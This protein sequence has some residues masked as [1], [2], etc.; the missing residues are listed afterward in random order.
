MARISKRA[1]RRRILPGAA[2]LIVVVAIL[3]S[4]ETSVSGPDQAFGF[5]V[6]WP[7]PN[8]YV[9]SNP[10][11]VYLGI[12]YT[13]S[14]TRNYTYVITVGS[15]VLTRGEVPIG[16]SSPFRVLV[17]APVPSELRAEVFVHGSLV[18][19]QNLTIG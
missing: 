12:N 2:L 4:Y 10:P 5:G 9:S 7:A 19:K 13:G 11:N 8:G 14:G 1:L 16:H 6:Y 3:A 18:Y 15:N 17:Y